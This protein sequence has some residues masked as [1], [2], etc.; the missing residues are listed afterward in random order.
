MGEFTN[1]N[2]K[3]VAAYAALPFIDSVGL[4]RQWQ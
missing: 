2:N 4:R 3:M 1:E